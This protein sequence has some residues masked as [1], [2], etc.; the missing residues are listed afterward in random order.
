MLMG[1]INLTVIGM[2]CGS[3]KMLV[4][5]ALNDL[6]AKKIKISVNEKIKVGEVSCEYED[7]NKIIKAIEAEGYKVTR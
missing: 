4:E 5:D 1:M 2:H 7:K 3:C 6:G